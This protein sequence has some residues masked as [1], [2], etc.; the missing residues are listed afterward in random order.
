MSYICDPE[1]WQG[2]PYDY[3]ALAAYN[4]QMYEKALALGEVAASL[5]PN[6]KQIQE[7]INWYRAKVK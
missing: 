4:Q 7:N 6:N 1:C 5:E 2:M 3:A